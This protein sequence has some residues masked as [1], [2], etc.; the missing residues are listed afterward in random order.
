MA[1]GKTFIQRSKGGLFVQEAPDDSFTF[2]TKVGVGAITVPKPDREARYEPGAMAGKFNIAGFIEGEP[3]EGSVTLTRPLSSV[4]NWLLEQTCPFQ[5]MVSIPCRGGRSLWENYWLQVLLFQAQVESGEI[6]ESVVLEPGENDRILTS[7][8]IIA[9]DVKLIY[10]LDGTTQTTETTTSG[11]AIE[12]FPE[13]CESECAEL[14]KKGQVAWGALVSAGYLAADSVIYTEDYGATWEAT[15]ADPFEGNRDCNDIMLIPTSGDYGYRVIV[16]GSGDPGHHAEISYTDDLGASW[17]DVEVG[18]MN[19]QAIN[20]LA[21]DYKGRIWA[22]A[23]DGMIYRSDDNGVS[24][25]LIDDAT[26]AND[27]YEI[28][29]YDEYTAMA[30][31]ESNTVLVSEDGGDTWTSVTGPSAGND[32]YCIDVN[33]FGHFYVGAADDALYMTDDEG[34]EWTE[35]RDFGSGAIKSIDFESDLRYG[36]WLV[37]N[38][39]SGDGYTYRSRDGGNTWDLLET[40]TNSGLEDIAAIDFNEALEIGDAH[41]GTTFVAKYAAG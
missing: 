4:Q 41:G 17:T 12:V 34:D 33:Y 30:V 16:A 31:G 2:L 20:G 7:A 39:G 26:T 19:S 10:S 1:G 22:V 23:S 25:E 11:Y 40:L 35:V 14:I 8:D 5:A 29:F 24:W 27:L 6:E 13:Q 37:R 32:L 28:V 21:L 18:E 38:D 3:S 15:A 36:G 9:A